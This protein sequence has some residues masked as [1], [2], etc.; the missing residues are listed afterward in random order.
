MQNGFLINV[1]MLDRETRDLYQFT[2][3]ATDNAPTPRSGFGT[4]SLKTDK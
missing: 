3:I 2:V 4:V 1:N